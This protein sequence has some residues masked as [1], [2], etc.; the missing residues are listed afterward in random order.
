LACYLSY[1]AEYFRYWEDQ[2]DLGDLDYADD[3][4]DRYYPD[5]PWV[6]E[7][8]YEDTD[9]RLFSF[10]WLLADEIIATMCYLGG[11]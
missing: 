10:A 1:R 5:N 9:P 3:L 6:D 4:W 2:E 7:E 8:D 11:R